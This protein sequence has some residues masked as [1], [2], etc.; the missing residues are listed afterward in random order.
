[1]SNKTGWVVVFATILGACFFVFSSTNRPVVAAELA[2][3]PM[4][5]GDVY[6]FGVAGQSPLSGPILTV[7][8]YPWVEV[9]VDG[10][11]ANIYQINLEHVIRIKHLT[12]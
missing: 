2:F 6:W 3:P 1:M 12:K 5:V 9:K 7:G 10:N 8:P 11:D 4:V